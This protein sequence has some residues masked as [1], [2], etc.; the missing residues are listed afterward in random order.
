MFHS[1]KSLNIL[2]RKFIIQHK[3]IIEKSQQKKFFENN[4]VN[5]DEHIHK[6]FEK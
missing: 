6:Y 2:V 1:L 5:F 3:D 4:Y